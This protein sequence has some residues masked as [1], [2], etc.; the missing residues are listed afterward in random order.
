MI[1]IGFTGTRNGMT[2][3]QQ[4]MV[5]GFL[6][7]YE[8]G[9]PFDIVRHGDCLG[10][11]AQFHEIVRSLFS[12]SMRKP[13]IHSHPPTNPKLRAFTQADVIHEP[14]EYK[15][16]DRDI[17]NQSDVLIAC[18]KLMELEQ[19]SGTA[20]TTKHALEVYQMSRQVGQHKEVI[21]IWPDG[22]Y[23]ITSK[24]EFD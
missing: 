16:R 1:A 22:S 11:D 21:I 23:D 7:D 4:Q 9:N 5:E 24:G 10:S 14:K 15:A 18:P 13:Q 6:M 3:E 20:Y 17:V 2:Q 8:N 12:K 19:W